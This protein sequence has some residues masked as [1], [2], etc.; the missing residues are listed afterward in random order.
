MHELTVSV[1]TYALPMRPSVLSGLR[2]VIGLCCAAAGLGLVLGV[3]AEW[4]VMA[5][6]LDTN[7]V[8]FVLIALGEAAAVLL[9]TRL[10]VGTTRPNPPP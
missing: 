10:L 7:P 3:A 6:L 2:L 4:G 8:L 9:L 5:G 1:E